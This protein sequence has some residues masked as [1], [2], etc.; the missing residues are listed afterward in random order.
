M[1][2]FCFGYLN[3]RFKVICMMRYIKSLISRIARGCME[4]SLICSRGSLREGVADGFMLHMTAGVF[5]PA[6]SGMP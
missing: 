6:E 3:M 1:G 2:L 4:A 5:Y